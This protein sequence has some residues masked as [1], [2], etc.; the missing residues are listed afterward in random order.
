MT[1]SVSRRGDAQVQPGCGPE[2]SAETAPAGGGRLAR[3]LGPGALVAVLLGGLY[4]VPLRALGPRLTN[5]PGDLFDGRFNNYVLEHGWLFLT[6]HQ[7]RFWDAPFFYPEPGVIAWS[8]CHLG[9]L[10]FYAVYRAVGC[11]RETAFQLW[12]ITL[13]VLNYLAAAWVLRRLGA[14]WLGAAAGAYVFAFCMPVATKIG[15]SQLYPRF[16]V[17]LAL[18][19][20]YRVCAG[21]ELRFWAGLGISIVWQMYATLYNGYFLV[22][23]LAVFVPTC[24]LL[25][26]R[27]ELRRWV[28]EHGWRPVVY[29]ALLLALALVLLPVRR[30]VGLAC[31]GLALADACWYWRGL[32]WRGAC[33]G[34]WRPFLARAVVVALCVAA[35]QPLVRPYLSVSRDHRR[36]LEEVMNLT[37]R[38]YSWFSAP[39]ASLLWP[40]LN[41]NAA[42]VPVDHEH[43]IFLGALPAA[44]LLAALGCA[45]ARRHPEWRE[46]AAAAA[47]AFAGVFVLTLHTE[48]FCLYTYLYAVPGVHAFRGVARV[49][50]VLV[51]PAAAALAYWLT[52]GQ[53][54]LTRRAGTTFAA[55]AVSL[56]L[57][58]V[59][60]DQALRREGFTTVAKAVCQERA[61]H[62]AEQVRRQFPE[63]RLFLNLQDRPEDARHDFFARAI[64]Q[65][66]DAMMASQ[67]LGIPTVN[68]YSGWGPR[69][70]DLFW[71]VQDLEHWK[72]AVRA[73]VGDR[74]LRR[75]IPGYAEHGFDGLAIMGRLRDSREQPRTAAGPLP[76]TGCRCRLEIREVPTSAAAAEAFPLTARVA[77]EGT[78]AWPSL[79]HHRVGLV[80]RWLM[81]DGRPVSGIAEGRVWL[82]HDLAPGT[83][84]DLEGEV[85][86]PPAPGEYILEIDMVQEDVGRFSERGAQPPVRRPITIRPASAGLAA[87]A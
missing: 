6:G 36:P 32:L 24:L 65:H 4:M 55:F 45:L 7:S 43:F 50:L 29:Q 13:C 20:A 79:G 77:N 22:L 3:W 26:W 25:R 59:A 19:F 8:D 66:L 49:G 1:T 10:P 42:K 67:D 73:R 61:R 85:V 56:L 70:Y 69:D 87:A 51:F 30:R 39:Q 57:P 17:P 58:L 46:F 48:K 34:A 27:A 62:L 75:R 31:A 53:A 63:A 16:A 86:T 35:T 78:T 64:L 18:Y 83:A 5:I 71:T 72:Q 44:A 11:D 54:W 12:F 9:T 84:V 15:H 23:L 2:P 80:Y 37:P 14:S 76:Q 68:G 21:G 28:A 74:R 40:I 33:G 47:L 38:I 60:A 52:A 41:R 81:P 82:A